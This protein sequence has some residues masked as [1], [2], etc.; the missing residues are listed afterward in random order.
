MTSPNNATNSAQLGAQVAEYSGN[1]IRFAWAV[2]LGVLSPI[3][4]IASVVQGSFAGLIF[5]LAIGGLAYWIYSF[6]RVLQ[7]R[8]Y[9]H[10]FV[11]TRG[12]TTTESRWADIADVSHRVTTWRLYFLI[13]VGRSHAYII[14]LKNGTRLR[15]TSSFN[16]EVRLGETIRQLWMKSVTARANPPTK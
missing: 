4:L 16:N 15:V 9:E 8:V 1:P 6:Q 5:W 2:I 13:P 10:G 3:G 12:G 7:A 11:M 14:T